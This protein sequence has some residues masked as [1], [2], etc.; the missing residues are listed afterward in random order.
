ML[1]LTILFAYVLQNPT[2]VIELISQLNTVREESLTVNSQSQVD[3]ILDDVFQLLS[4]FFMAL[5]KT[6]DST[7]SYVQLA[8]IKVN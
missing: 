5:G 7:A 6:K 3:D 8:T 4:L 1:T 2:Q